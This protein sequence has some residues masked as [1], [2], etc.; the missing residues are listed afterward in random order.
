MFTLFKTFSRDG[1]LTWSHPEA[2]LA[3]SGC[4]VSRHHP[5]AGWPAVCVLLRENSRRRNSYVI[6]QMTKA[7]VDQAE[8]LASLTATATPLHEGRSAI[9]LL[10][11]APQI[12]DPGDW[13]AWVGHWHAK[14][15]EGQSRG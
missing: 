1:G 4:P 15:E 7:N 13:V 2:I 12:A 14:G 10:R 5:F 6:F 8:E 9:H 11:I 3:R